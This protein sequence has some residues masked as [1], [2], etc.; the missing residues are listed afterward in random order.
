MILI[1]VEKIVPLDLQGFN[2]YQNECLGKQGLGPDTDLCR[3]ITDRGNELATILYRH[4]DG[5][6]FSVSFLK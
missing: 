2:V 5:F 1:S 3:A 4:W 6:L